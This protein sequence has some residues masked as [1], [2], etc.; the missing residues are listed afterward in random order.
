MKYY[1]LPLITL[2]FACSSSDD[3]ENSSNNFNPPEKLISKMYISSINCV[4]GNFLYDDAFEMDYF[5]D[6]SI[7]NSLT[8]LNCEFD[9]S[10]EGLINCVDYTDDFLGPYL[11]VGV[12]QYEQFPLNNELGNFFINYENGRISS[13]IPDDVGSGLSHFYYW[14]N[15]NMS[16]ILTYLDDPNN[17]HSSTN[18]VYT[19]FDNK[20]RLFSP[21]PIM[22]MGWMIPLDPLGYMGAFGDISVKLPLRVELSGINDDTGYFEHQD[23]LQFSYQLDDQGF[24][25][26]YTVTY[27]NELWFTITIEYQ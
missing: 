4:N 22:D 1:L 16:S 5:Y 9:C 12:S 6:N 26:S 18:F 21:S 11:S 20:S 13:K 7:M 2:I 8:Y 24:V 25:T 3:S 10:N 23:T 17:L 15:E 14:E 27:E 19:D